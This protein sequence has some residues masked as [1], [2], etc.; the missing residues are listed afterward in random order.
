MSCPSCAGVSKGESGRK[1]ECGYEGSSG[2][3]KS[4]SC[5][6]DDSFQKWKKEILAQGHEEKPE[7]PHSG[8]VDDDC[9][10][11]CRRMLR[12]QKPQP[13]PG[14]TCCTFMLA[15]AVLLAAG[16]TVALIKKKFID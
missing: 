6:G 11:L 4:K 2:R 12:K 5:R 9:R 7:V 1:N 15:A 14:C 13:K 3:N 8:F 16:V 10:E